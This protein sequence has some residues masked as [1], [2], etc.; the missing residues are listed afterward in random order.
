MK[1]F[2]FITIFILICSF[3]T[4]LAQ[5]VVIT[6]N[7]S[8]VK[9]K[10][11]TCSYNQ[12]LLYYKA[13]KQA[14]AI[15]KNGNFKFEFNITGIK[16]V[17]LVID[18]QQ[19]S[20]YIQPGDNI[21][22]KINYKD[23]DKSIVFTGYNSEKNNLLKAYNEK[24]VF[25]HESDS[26]QQNANRKAGDYAAYCDSLLSEELSFVSAFAPK[27]SNEFISYFK[28]KLVY[29]NANNKLR[30][31]SY[32]AYARHKGDT[33]PD[34]PNNYFNFMDE[35]PLNN[36]S[37]LA[38]PA[39]Y[40]YIKAAGRHYQ[41]Y[42]IASDAPVASL[43][44]GLL[45]AAKPGTA[46]KAADML[47]AAK[48]IFKNDKVLKVYEASVIYNAL[49]YE[50][51]AAT[52]KL[53]LQYVKTNAKTQYRDELTEVYNK[54]M[55]VAPGQTAPAFT[56]MDE[57]GKACSLADYKGKVVYLDF[58]ASWCG[59]CLREL[60]YS[61]K[62]KEEFEGKDVVFLYVSIDDDAKSWKDAIAKKS[63]SGVHVNAPDFDHPVSQA[64]NIS[65]VP[66]YFLIG[67]DGRII[68][69]NPPRPSAEAEV[70]KEIGD[71]LQN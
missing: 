49:R 4:M 18:E 69:N 59:P 44:A 51:F 58:W 7:V 53:Y 31:P 33:L 45:Q 46:V 62:L 48:T 57:K 8:K 67:K 70:R 65:G 23:F 3:N 40:D 25:G 55:K 39:Y 5:K 56:L 19:T 34:M 64:Y 16:E 22:I 71:A 43:S 30:Y 24:F 2:R 6:G 10:E 21:F 68:S 32:W 12:G 14:A 38:N 20:F 42:S 1:T 27:P 54:V 52:E 13:A 60:P 35:L 66:T 63:I 47:Q 17:Y 15:D 9:V 41:S 29:E 26:Y 36:D 11:A 37:L 28:T 61:K 50:E